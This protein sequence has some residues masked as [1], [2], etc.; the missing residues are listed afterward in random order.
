MHKSHPDGKRRALV[1]DYPT[2]AQSKSRIA[3]KQ[4][5][6]QKEQEVLDMVLRT[7]PAGNPQAVLDAIDHYGW[8][9][10][11][12]MNIGDRKGAIV[13]TVVEKHQPKVN[14]QMN[15]LLTPCLQIAAP[16]ILAQNS[17]AKEPLSTALPTLCQ[18]SMC[19]C[20]HTAEAHERL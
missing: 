9:T 17:I 18:C 5:E 3:V 14:L 6:G 20:L 2:Q 10:S 4:G 15:L 8:T 7:V 11:F 13:D 1:A 19:I 12:L 16:H